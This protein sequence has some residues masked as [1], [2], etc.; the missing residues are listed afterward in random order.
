MLETNKI[1]QNIVKTLAFFSVFDYPLTLWEVWKFFPIETTFYEIRNVIESIDS[2]GSKYGFYYLKKD[3]L[4]MVRERLTRYGHA[5]RKYK[6]LNKY[7]FIFKIIPWVEGVA[8]ANLIGQHNL[9]GGGD[10]DIFVITKKN[11][12][13]LTRF[14]SISF[15]KIFNLRPNKK[16]SKDKI[17]LSFFVDKTAL[18]LQNLMINNDDW[19]FVYWLANL[20]FVYER[21]G[22]ST[23][24]FDSN[25]W[26]NKYLPN[27]TIR[28]T[29][30]L[31]N[32]NVCQR[33]F[34]FGS[35]SLFNLIEKMS[36]HFQVKI[37]PSHINKSHK[38]G[39]ILV[40][41]NIIKLHS[42]DRRMDILN[43]W[44]NKIAHE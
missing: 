36:F 4:G 29:I 43:K 27:W 26:I 5:D 11:R 8:M 25:S 17:C 9:R 18:N 12:V 40:K 23:L 13:W 2:V 37:F 1:E 3:G 30:H 6:I 34:N 33:V 38:T 14:F 16:T 28:N 20:C 42:N 7:L 22:S 31:R 19:Y 41:K 35:I 10:I 44:N 15:L 32:T 21:N 39:G 24:F